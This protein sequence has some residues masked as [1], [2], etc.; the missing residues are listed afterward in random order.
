MA[1]VRSE[2]NE[3][4]AIVDISKLSHEQRLAIN[5]D[6]IINIKDLAMMHSSATL[7]MISGETVGLNGKLYMAT[8]HFVDLYLSKIGRA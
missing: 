6:N 4:F 5:P 3:R 8:R 1:I 2:L 7:A